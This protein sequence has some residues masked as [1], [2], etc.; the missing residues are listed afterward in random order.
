M[1]FI[2]EIIFVSFFRYNI[3]RIKCFID[4]YVLL[5]LFVSYFIGRR[6]DSKK[7]EVKRKKC[8]WKFVENW[9]LKCFVYSFSVFSY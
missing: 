9:D 2:L 5:E 6:R 3:I 7:V 1:I 4:W 8:N